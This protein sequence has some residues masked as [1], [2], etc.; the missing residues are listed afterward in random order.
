MN[1]CVPEP[2]KISSLAIMLLVVSMACA[3]AA[4]PDDKE[5]GGGPE[6]EPIVDPIE[7]ALSDE[8][9]CSPSVL[10]VGVGHDHLPSLPLEKLIDGAATIVHASGLSRE[11]ARIPDSGS[12]GG[13][14]KPKCLWVVYADVEVHEYLKGEGPGTL[15]VALP[16]T[17]IPQVDRPLATVVCQ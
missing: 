4:A 2:A 6:S 5:L 14:G 3:P 16:V 17:E 7:G 9:E 12:G 10:G 15:R 11:Q 1:T 8:M 13:K